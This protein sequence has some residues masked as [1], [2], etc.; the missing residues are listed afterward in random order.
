MGGQPGPNLNL[1][2]ALGRSM[3]L[4]HAPYTR[5]YLPSDADGG[6]VTTEELSSLETGSRRHASYQTSG[7]AEIRYSWLALVGIRNTTSSS[8]LLRFPDTN[9]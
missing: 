7:S 3:H 1:G 9:H 4:A 8:R 2:I 6:L 5:Q